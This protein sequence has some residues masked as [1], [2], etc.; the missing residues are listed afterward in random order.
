MSE[1]ETKLCR[2]CGETKGWSEF[3]FN[4]RWCRPNGPCKACHGLK[5]REQVR[6]K[7]IAALAPWDRDPG[8][9]EEWRPIPGHDGFEAS[10]M[11][12]IRTWTPNGHAR[13]YDRLPEP[14]I[15][16]TYKNNRGYRSAH[17]GGGA[18]ALVSRLVLT[19]FVGEP[20]PGM[21]ACHGNGVRADNRLVNLRWATKKENEADKIRHGT[22]CHG[23]RGT[24][25]KMTLEQVVAIKQ[26]VA[27]GERTC[28]LA[29]RLGIS[30]Q[31]VTEIKTGRTWRKALASLETK[32]RQP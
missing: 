21:E 13:H 23:E 3:Y 14:T 30:R 16:P 29:A 25:A 8:C 27:A 28:A 19:A 20:S 4:K 31:R 24:S 18:R 32:G 2:V 17:L 15:V 6:A 10:D 5:R 1:L 7:R 11:G 12:R 22:L 9:P 26:A